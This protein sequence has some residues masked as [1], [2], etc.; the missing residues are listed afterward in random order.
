MNTITDIDFAILD[1]IRDN[2]TTGVGD[3]IMPMISAL[4]NGGIIWIVFTVI[5]LCIKKYRKAGIVMAIALIID[6]LLCNAFLKPLVARPRPFDVRPWI[7][8]II[9]PPSDYSFPS[10]HT[11]ASFAVTAALFFVKNKMWRVSCVMAALIAFT[12]LYLYVH[13]PTDILGG[14]AVGIMSGFFAALIKNK[15][16]ENILSKQK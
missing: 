4:G 3:I 12:R 2:L 14:I 1:F 15:F 6:L 10:G 13:Y 9:P 5:M 16:E 8:L 11:A 7:E